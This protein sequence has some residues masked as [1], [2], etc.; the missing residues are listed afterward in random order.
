LYDE[1][2][3][4]RAR[5]PATAATI[6]AVSGIV[7]SMLAMEAIHLLTGAIRPASVDTVLIL[8]LKTMSFSAEKIA[9]DAR[10]PA[11]A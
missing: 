3:E 4:H 7:G 10:C 5:N 2:A 1:I 6:G 9:R 8:D 11:C